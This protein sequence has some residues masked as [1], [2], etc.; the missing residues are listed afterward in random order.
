MHVWV[1]R[2]YG[3]RWSC[4]NCLAYGTEDTKAEAYAALRDH[5]LTKHAP[6]N[7]ALEREEASPTRGAEA[8]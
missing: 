1:K 2:G 8:S 4:P 5:T 6:L 7:A 3:F